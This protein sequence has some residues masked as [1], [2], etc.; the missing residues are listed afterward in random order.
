MLKGLPERVMVDKGTEWNLVRDVIDVV[1]MKSVYN[2]VLITNFVS[3]I[4]SLALHRKNREH[5]LQ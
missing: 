3:P 1:Q 5:Q 4:F 2:Q